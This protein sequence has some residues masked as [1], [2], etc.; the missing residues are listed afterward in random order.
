MR[1]LRS[2]SVFL[3]LSLLLMQR[4]TENLWITK[5][6]S[7]KKNWTHEYPWKKFRTH[8]KKIWTQEISIRNILDTLNTHERKL[9]IREIPMKTRWHDDTKPT[10][11]LNRMYTNA[12]LKIS[13]Y[14][15]VHI[16]TI[17]WKFRI[18]NLKN[19][20]VIYPWSS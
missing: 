1:G 12:H 6:T 11:P 9:P 18:L 19:S 14:A 17:P 10:R 7:R 3:L 8:E 16:K 20:W 5:S 4:A 13:L 2:I 15:C